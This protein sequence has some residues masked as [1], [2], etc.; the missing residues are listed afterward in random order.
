MIEVLDRPS[1]PVR[2]QDSILFPQQQHSVTVLEDLF[3]FFLFI[4]RSLFKPHCVTVSLFLVYYLVTM[5]FFLYIVFSIL[6]IEE[7]GKM[8]FLCNCESM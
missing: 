3:F 8:L 1:T 6:V 7:K 5:P 2:L 4:C